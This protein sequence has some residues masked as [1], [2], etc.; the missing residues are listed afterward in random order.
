MKKFIPYITFICLT[1]SAATS[2]LPIMAGSCSGYG[3]K[4]SEKKCD[5]DDTDC[6]KINL[7]RMILVKLSNL[8]E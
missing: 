3:N 4:M 8:N 2:G 7:K 1:L 5:K 6:Q